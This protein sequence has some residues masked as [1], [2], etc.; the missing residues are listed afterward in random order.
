MILLAEKCIINPER[1][2]LGLAKANR[3]EEEIDNIRNST[4]K[5][6]VQV[7]KRLTDEIHTNRNTLNEHTKSLAR[8]ETLYSSMEELPSTIASLDKTITIIGNNLEAISKNL[9][10][11]KSDVQLQ[12]QTIHDINKK[13]ST[14][15]DKITEIDNKSKVDWSKFITNNFWKII[16]IIGVGYV[17]IQQI[18]GSGA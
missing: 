12:S 15:S 10:E 17:L 9:E 3:L 18:L 4:E 5:N 7:E 13:S 16:A 2:C 6:I 8:L 14:N 11:V 1:D